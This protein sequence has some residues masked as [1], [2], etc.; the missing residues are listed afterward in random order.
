MPRRLDPF[1]FFMV[2]VAGWMNQRHQQ[3][4]NM[5][6]PLTISGVAHD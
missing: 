1:Q 3:V 5:A 6:T 4:V 2:A